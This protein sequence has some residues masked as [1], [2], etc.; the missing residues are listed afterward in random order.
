M[1]LCYII[2]I[3]TKNIKRC[4]KMI[5]KNVRKKLAIF[6][7]AVVLI[8]VA[9]I[10]CSDGALRFK[11]DGATGNLIDTE[12]DRYYI[13]CKGYLKAAEIKPK[14]Y[15]RGDGGE[16]LYE[17]PGIDPAK[18]LSEDIT[19]GVPFLFREQSEEEPTF[20]GFEAVKIHITETEVISIAVGLI[21]D[22][23]DVGKIVNDFLY[24]EETPYPDVVTDYFDLNFESEKY[25]GIYYVLQYLVDDKNN[26]YLYD[27]WTGRCVECS[28]KLF[29]GNGIGTGTLEEG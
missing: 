12:N 20:E 26:G 4:V 18:W 6:I 24:N 22:P 10:S 15:A 5:L 27:R 17:I 13:Y 29:G 14:I 9:L 11:N 21:G 25:T 19:W 16:K 8:S 1:L 2:D 23:E 28:I 7:L 3:I